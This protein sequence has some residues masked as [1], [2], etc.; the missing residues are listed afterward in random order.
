MKKSL[1]FILV[2]LATANVY[3]DA[4]ADT[5]TPSDREPPK[6]TQGG[7]TRNTEK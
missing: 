4:D 6:R 7:G 3:I 1:L 2:L 5:Y